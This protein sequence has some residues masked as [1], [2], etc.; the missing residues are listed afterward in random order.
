MQSAELDLLL[1]CHFGMDSSS[2]ESRHKGP[3]WVPH[4]VGG[5]SQQQREGKTLS[6]SLWET[7]GQRPSEWEQ[8]EPFESLLPQDTATVTDSKVGRRVRKPYSEHKGVIR[9]ALSGGCWRWRWKWTHL[10]GASE[11]V[12]GLGGMFVYWLHLAVS[13]KGG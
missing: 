3:P 1:I 12:I 2:H 11:H 10:K 13:C 9:W 8:I 5:W 6:W 4:R 7:C